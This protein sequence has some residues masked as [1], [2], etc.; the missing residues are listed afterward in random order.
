MT[1]NIRAF[2]IACGLVWGVGLFILPWWIMVTG[3]PIAQQTFLERVYVGYTFTPLGS[4]IGLVWGFVDGLVGG[5]IFAW[6]YNVLAKK[7]FA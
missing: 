4:V 1:L 6:L 2:G 3:D 7:M 5:L